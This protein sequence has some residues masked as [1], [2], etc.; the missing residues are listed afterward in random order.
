MQAAETRSPA[1]AA[2]PR[3]AGQ[4]DIPGAAAAAQDDDAQAVASAQPAP[5]TASEDAEQAQ[6]SASAAGTH[7]ASGE[8]L[9]AGTS[10]TII[11]VA[12]D[13]NLA[14]WGGRTGNIYRDLGDKGYEVAMPNTKSGPKKFVK[15][16]ANQVQ[17]V[18]NV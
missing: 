8:R 12:L 11:C 16:A 7:A 9:P 17:E 10:V 4:G 13:T 15:F 6:A 5:V 14:K 18:A 2:E 1:D 3:D